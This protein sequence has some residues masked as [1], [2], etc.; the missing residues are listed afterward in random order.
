MQYFGSTQSP[1][2]CADE[3]VDPGG[4]AMLPSR[5]AKI[6]PSDPIRLTVHE[7]SNP[8]TVHCR[9]RV[10]GRVIKHLPSRATDDSDDSHRVSLPGLRTAKAGAP[11]LL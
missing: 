4:T 8:A 10:I 7:V 3:P 11:R 1:S 9:R 5:N 2:V 6:V